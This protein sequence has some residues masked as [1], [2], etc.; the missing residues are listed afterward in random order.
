MLDYT[1]TTRA[2]SVKQPRGGYLKPSSM[3][4]IVFIIRK[5]GGKDI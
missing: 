3:Q 1:V 5:N 2:N 4:K